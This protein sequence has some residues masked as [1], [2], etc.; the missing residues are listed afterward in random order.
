MRKVGS[1]RLRTARVAL[2]ACAAAM[3][4][5]G[6]FSPTTAHAHFFLVSPPNWVTSNTGSGAPEKLA[7]CGNEAAQAPDGVPSGVITALSS[8]PDGTT[9]VTVTIDEVVTHAGWYRVSVVPGRSSTQTTTTLPD[10]PTPATSCAAT[11]ETTPTLPVVADNVFRHQAAFTQAQT[12]QIKLPASLACTHA[13]PCTL[14]VVEVMNDGGHLPPGCFY[15]HCA[16]IA[17]ATAADGGGNASDAATNGDA[18]NATDAASGSG[19]Q[20]GSGASSGSPA[21]SPSTAS[22]ASSG[23]PAGSSGAQSGSAASGAPA[24]SA[25]GVSSGANGSTSGAGVPSGGADAG[26]AASDGGAGGCALS[27]RGAPTTFAFLGGLAA[28]SIVARRRRTRR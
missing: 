27:G 11:I 8:N 12:V 6:V 18:S 13:T 24:S 23:A 7:P 20:S 25:S 5:F 4:A 28:L 15:H 16:D 22:G 26:I 14:Q 1:A 2:V 9:S 3:G 21:P 19:A 17:I 10:P